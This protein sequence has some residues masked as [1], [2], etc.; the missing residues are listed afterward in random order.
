MLISLGSH[1]GLFPSEVDMLIGRHTAE[2]QV[3]L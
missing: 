3:A 1:G 2:G